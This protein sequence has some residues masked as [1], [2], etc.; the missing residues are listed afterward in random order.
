V[1]PAVV[2]PATASKELVL[3]NRLAQYYYDVILGPPDDT[4]IPVSSYLY[5]IYYEFMSAAKNG[6]SL[7]SQIFM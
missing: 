3:A 7:C 6:S 4:P 2:V 1:A 5:I